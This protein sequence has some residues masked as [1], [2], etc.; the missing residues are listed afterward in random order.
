LSGFAAREIDEFRWTGR[1]GG[2]LFVIRALGRDL[3]AGCH[4]LTT[5]DMT[6]TSNLVFE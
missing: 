2:K 4:W 1:A 3:L 6:G 5:S